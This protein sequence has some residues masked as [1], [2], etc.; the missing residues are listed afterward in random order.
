MKV[1]KQSEC[2]TKSTISA[3]LAMARIS[4]SEASSTIGTNSTRPTGAAAEGHVREATARAEQQRL[5][6]AMRIIRQAKVCDSSSI[7]NIEEDCGRLHSLIIKN[8][9]LFPAQYA[10]DRVSLTSHLYPEN[11]REM[12]V[13]SPRMK[14]FSQTTLSRGKMEIVFPRR[15]KDVSKEHRIR[16]S[17]P[18]RFTR[19]LPFLSIRRRILELLCQPRQFPVTVRSSDLGSGTYAGSLGSSTGAGLG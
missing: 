11:L 4:T 14:R 10:L 5:K 13:Q 18:R 2:K 16:P 3:A 7:C 19:T 8:W 17:F 1:S 12:R 6:K 9:F 15:A